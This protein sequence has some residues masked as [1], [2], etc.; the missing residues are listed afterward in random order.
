MLLGAV[1]MTELCARAANCLRGRGLIV[2]KKHDLTADHKDGFV[3]WV[4]IRTRCAARLQDHFSQRHIGAGEIP[5]WQIVFD[6]LLPARK[7]R[8]RQ[9]LRQ[10]LEIVAAAERSEERRV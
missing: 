4:T 8:R 10:P 1:E 6:L 7:Q 2:K 3:S 9:F 5:A